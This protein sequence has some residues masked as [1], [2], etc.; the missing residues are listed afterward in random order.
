[1]KVFL[2]T[3]VLASA[4]VA[5]GTCAELFRLVLK[6]HELITSDR[7]LMELERVLPKLGATA[8]ETAK[9]IA[10]LR[11]HRVEKTPRTA[12]AIRLRDKDDLWILA[13][14]VEARADV[15]VT[16]DKDLLDIAAK[17]PLK[18]VSP[19]GFLEMLA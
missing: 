10:I 9:A 12:P 3:N 2:D 19:R 18:I 17:S 5:S 4:L 11:Q 8:K 1:M 7:V 14:A 16:G 6:D 13:A 15:L